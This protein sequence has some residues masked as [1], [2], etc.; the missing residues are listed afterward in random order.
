LPNPA[1]ERKPPV[2]PQLPMISRTSISLIFAALISLGSAAGASPALATAP[3]GLLW[4]PAGE[5]IRIQFLGSEKQGYEVR[6]ERKTGDA[7][8][9]AGALAPGQVW[10][11][12]TGWRDGWFADPQSIRA[13]SIKELP[14]GDIQATAQ[15]TVGGE[16]WQFSDI[17]HADGGFLRIQRLFE[18]TGPGAQS[19]ITL[20]NRVRVPLGQDPRTLIPGSIYNGNPGSILPGPRLVCS[21]GS[22]GLYEEHR[23]P[24]PFVN[25]ESS[26]D[27]QR[28]SA[29]LLAIPS[30][31]PM[32]HKGDDQWWSLGI[33]FG[34]GFAD[35]LS[36]SGPLAGNAGRSTFYGHRSGFDSYDDAW[37]DVHGPARFEKIL[38]LELGAGAKPGY[39]FQSILWKAFDV[40]HPVDTPHIPFAQAIALRLPFIQSTFIRG[41]GDAAGFRMFPNNQ[42]VEFGWL[43]ENLAIACGILWET[44]RVPNP[45]LRDDAIATVDFFVHHAPSTVPGLALGRYDVAA[46]RWSGE[47]F[48]RLGACVASRQFGEN[49]DHLASCVEI[50]EEQKLPQAAEWRKAFLQECDFLV[51]TPRYCGM[52]PR[53]WTIDGKPLGDITSGAPRLSTAGSYCVSPLA[54]ATQ[55]T[56]DPKYAKAAGELMSAYCQTFLS[57]Q[58]SPPWGATLDAGGE[59]KEAG[60]GLLHG[61][62]SL[63]DA[64]HQSQWLDYAREA[65][66]WTLTWMYFH[67]VHVFHD[68]N[69]KGNMNTV[70]WTFI[71]TQ[72]QEID[73]FGYWMAPDYY[74]LGQALNDDRYRQIGTVLYETCTQTIARPGV[75]LGFK[76]LGIQAEHYNNTNCTYGLHA[77]WRGTQMSAGI[78]WV[79][80]AVLYGGMQISRLAPATFSLDA[81]AAPQPNS[82]H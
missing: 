48:Y 37:L 14:G 33:E 23:L 3:Q 20:V 11:V 69:L 47:T 43:G 49:L 59:D 25:L 70:G 22:I 12:C 24:V 28:R 51:A 1:Q 16:P 76:V 57:D 19:Q 60:Y 21:S 53:G 2:A 77:P 55:M 44:A 46:D 52:L 80:A 29:S 79:N 45:A 27:G 62:L 54:R 41:K 68:P 6:F 67:D 34:D 36:T 32:G 72:N 58:S 38:Y 56:G 71:S 9:D 75:M 66:D 7:W 39:A 5:D 13:Q 50:A 4:S 18:H 42:I 26:V 65:A 30:K 81:P 31:V 35:L 17:Y 40:F 78:G 82:R 73:C 61:L 74:R 64:T 10:T 8:S 15:A 63:Y